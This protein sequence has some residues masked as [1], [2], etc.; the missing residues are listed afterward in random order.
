MSATGSPKDSGLPAIDVLILAG[1]RPGG[2]PLLAHT[3]VKGK[4][5]VP[6]A[7]KPVLARVM[8]AVAAWPRCARIVLVAPKEPAYQRLV[9]STAGGKDVLWMTPQSSLFGSIG[10]ALSLDG[11]W[12]DQ[13]LI[14]SGDHGLAVSTWFDQVLAGLGGSADLVVGMADWEAVMSAYPGS[15]RTRYRFQDGSVCGGNVFAFRR[16]GMEKILASWAQ[17]EHQRKRPWRML[18]LL[19]PI[20]V[21]RYLAGR[22]T[23]G[24]AF[25][26]L[27]SVVGASVAS[28]LV[29]DPAI[30]VDIDS[31]EDLVLAKRIVRDREGL[32]KTD[33]A[34]GAD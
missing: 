1:D 9:E 15:K 11:V 6:L 19:G 13:G 25:D 32:A 31:V 30:A 20:H 26:R 28:Q 22:L 23:R 21:A 17:V 16:S 29:D 3:G 27:S 12:Q 8:E 2:S 5:L 24:E 14:V 18:S 7:G 10:D 33:L 4:A 34:T